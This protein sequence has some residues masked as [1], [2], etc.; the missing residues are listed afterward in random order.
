M[1]D[2]YKMV[3]ESLV[4]SDKTIV[5]DFHKWGK[6]SNI[7]F[8][9]GMPAS[10]KTTLSVELS[11]KYNT[12]LYS[13]DKIW[14]DVTNELE[15]FDINSGKDMPISDKEFARRAYDIIIKKTSSNN[16]KWVVEGIKTAS[17]YLDDIDGKFKELVDNSPCVMMGT[18]MIKALYRN[19]IRTFKLRKYENNWMA[20]IAQSFTNAKTFEQRHHKFK[21]MRLHVSN[22]KIELLSKYM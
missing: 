2:K 7:I 22:T 15:G 6:D 8:V 3:Q 14:S 11:K 18:S 21:Q 20:Y 19:V 4:F 16:D 10:G 17:I 9:D 12:K 1:N 13:L 5:C